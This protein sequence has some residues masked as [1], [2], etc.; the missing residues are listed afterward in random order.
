MRR[1]KNGEPIVEKHGCNKGV[2]Y[3]V[4]QFSPNEWKWTIYP[5]IGSGIPAK[6]GKLNGTAEEADA[7]CRA[8]IEQA[9]QKR[10][11]R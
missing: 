11:L 7:A 5:K 3:S 8:A 1:P 6:H 4:Q 10:A 9:F 2:E